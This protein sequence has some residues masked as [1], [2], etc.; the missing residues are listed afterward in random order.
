MDPISIVAAGLLVRALQEFAGEAG[1]T[2]WTTIRDALARVRTRLRGD[3]AARA[4]LAAAEEDPE[5][6][7][8]TQQ[9]AA[10]IERL[11]VEDDSFRRDVGELVAAARRDPAAARF[12]TEVSGHAHVEKIVNIES[13]R[14]VSF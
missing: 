12:V 1:R 4:A 13:A 9:L 3:E 5:D 2:S 11:S 14:D 8:R 10:T 6:E 7:A